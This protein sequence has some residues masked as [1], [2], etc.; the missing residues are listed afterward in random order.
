MEETGTGGG[1]ERPVHKYRAGR[2]NSII[3]IASEI[4]DKQ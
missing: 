1:F 2:L 3:G 4:E